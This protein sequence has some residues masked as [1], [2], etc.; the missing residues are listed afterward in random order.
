MFLGMSI[1]RFTRVGKQHTVYVLLFS[2]FQ[3]KKGEIERKMNIHLPILL[4][5]V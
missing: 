5:S 1:L 3:E 4:T 2:I